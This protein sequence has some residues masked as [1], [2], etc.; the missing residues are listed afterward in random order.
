ME[1]RYLIGGVAGAVGV[2]TATI[3]GLFA[4]RRF[5]YIRRIPLLGPDPDHLVEVRNEREEAHEVAVDVEVD[6]EG[7]AHGPWT[8]D[9]GKHWG[10]RR[11]HSPGE[12]EL[13]VRVDGEEELTEHHEAPISDTGASA[14][15]IT[16]HESGFVTARVEDREDER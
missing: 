12:V 6:G 7:M 1:R 8:I 16:L 9:P 5:G 14:A 13:T 15:V 2:L 3:A 4:A 11:I 10:V